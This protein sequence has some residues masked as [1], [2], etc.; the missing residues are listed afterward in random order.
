MLH[1][2]S[3]ENVEVLPSQLDQAV[4]L[5]RRAMRDDRLRRE[6]IEFAEEHCLDVHRPA[7][8]WDEDQRWGMVA[9]ALALLEKH[10]AAKEHMGHV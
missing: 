3:I 6:Q 2:T 8:L 4:T 10:P 1:L 5:L 7:P 9:D